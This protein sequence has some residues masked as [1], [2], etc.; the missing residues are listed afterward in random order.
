MTPDG[1]PVELYL[2]LPAAG[3]PEIVHDAIPSGASILELGSGCGRVTHPLLDL[4]HEVV[5]VD[6]SPEMLAHVRG[7]KTVCTP[8]ADLHL[9]RE[10]DVVLLASHLINTPDP[11][12]RHALLTAAR[13]HLTPSGRLLVEWHPPDWFDHV[14]PGPGGHLGEVAVSLHNLVHEAD[15]LS[16]TVQYEAANRVWHQEFT[17]RRLDPPALHEALTSADLTFDRWVTDDRDWF[18]ARGVADH[19]PIWV[20]CVISR[21]TS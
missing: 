16:A 21:T 18:S 10:F 19:V 6:E 3:E 9:D 11:S 8:I 14:T 7:A 1:C 15:L 13:R 5:A 12:A 17:C 2:Q 4:G 20:P